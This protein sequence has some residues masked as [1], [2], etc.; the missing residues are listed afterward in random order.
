MSPE[1]KVK[2]AIKEY[3]DTI[4]L[5]YMWHVAF[6]SVGYT[7][8]G[9]PDR[10]LCYRGRFLA[11]EVKAD[12][13]KKPTPWQAREIAAINT[14]GGEA[15]VVWNVDQVK[16]LIAMIDAEFDPAAEQVA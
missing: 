4:P 1:T 9:V 16:Q 12:E 7:K 8:K 6:H 3:L 5:D 11:I 14:A 2:H 15:I 13:T 10:L